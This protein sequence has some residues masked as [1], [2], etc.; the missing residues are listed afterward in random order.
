MPATCEYR[1][2]GKN[3]TWLKAKSRKDDWVR[4]KYL[5]EYRVKASK[6]PQAAAR[7]FDNVGK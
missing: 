7:Y 3:Y 2:R 4:R 5:E 1:F 6:N